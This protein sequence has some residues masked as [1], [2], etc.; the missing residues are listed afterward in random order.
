VNS[1]VN[2]SPK[3]N[4]TLPF[5][6]KIHGGILAKR[7]DDTHVAE[8]AKHNI[9]PVDLVVCNLYPFVEVCD[10]YKIQSPP[11]LLKLAI[12]DHEEI[13]YKGV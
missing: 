6:V 2:S 5:V 7:S 10:R 1:L 3:A 4:S 9:A 8:L 12:I 13:Q 11:T